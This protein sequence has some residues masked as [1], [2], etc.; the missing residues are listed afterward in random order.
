MFGVAIVGAA[1]VLSRAAEAAQVDIG[2]GAAIALPALL[3]VLP[4]YAVDLVFTL[5]AGQVYAANGGTCVPGPPLGLLSAL[6]GTVHR[7]R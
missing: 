6:A 1:F 5:R 7:H 2:A 4:E 3:A